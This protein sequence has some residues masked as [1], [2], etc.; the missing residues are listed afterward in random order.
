[1]SEQLIVDE[2][3][4]LVR[5]DATV[6]CVIVQLHAFANRDQF[7]QLMNAGLAYYKAH[8]RPGQCWGWIADTRHMSAIPKEVQ[9]WLADDWNAQAC[10][11]GLR[12]M[13]IVTSTNILGQLAMQQYVDKAVAQPER[14][15]LHPI[16]YASLEEAKRGVTRRCATL[17]AG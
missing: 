16:Y 9:Q 11:A 3:Y 7:K 12:E 15:V 13:S 14:Y 10:Q 8:S 17:N 1:M 5:A 6:P 4:A 2:P